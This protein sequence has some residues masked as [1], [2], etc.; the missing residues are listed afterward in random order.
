MCLWQ[1][2]LIGRNDDICHFETNDPKGHPKYD[3][4]LMTKVRW[5]KNISEER[6]CPDQILFG[7]MDDCYCLL[8][9]LAVYLESYL[10]QFPMA[11]HLFTEDT[12]TK[13]V[14]RLKNRYRKN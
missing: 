12:S 4:A 10:Y 9:Q 13:A 5:S 11:H 3:F 8:I 14:D 2:T 1:Y 6:N 7:S